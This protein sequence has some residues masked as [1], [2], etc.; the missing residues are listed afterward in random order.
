ML[1]FNPEAEFLGVIETKVVRV[2]LLDIHS[3]LY[4][5]FNPPPFPE[6]KWFETGL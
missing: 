2:F 5:G 3:H 1:G 4:Y 6:Q